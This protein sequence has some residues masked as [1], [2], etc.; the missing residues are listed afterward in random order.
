M[1]RT[2]KRPGKSGK[3]KVRRSVPRTALERSLQEKRQ[4][5]LRIQ[6]YIR[7]FTA[8]AALYAAVR[9]VLRLLWT[10]FSYLRLRHRQEEH[11]S[12]S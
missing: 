11:P 7:I 6:K 4:K 12:A 9:P 8:L 10:V 2:A 1:S 3:E 5:L